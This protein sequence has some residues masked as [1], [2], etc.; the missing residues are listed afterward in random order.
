MGVE[1]EVP[2]GW[3]MEEAGV[4]QRVC[5]TQ[6]EAVLWHLREVEEEPVEEE[7]RGQTWWEVRE[8]MTKVLPRAVEVASSGWRAMSLQAE[9]MGILWK[10]E[11]AAV[12]HQE[13]VEQSV[14]LGLALTVHGVQLPSRTCM[15]SLGWLQCRR[16]H[17]CAVWASRLQKFH[18]A[19]LPAHWL[20]HLIL[21]IHLHYCF[22]VCWRLG[23][24][25]LEAQV[26]K[27]VS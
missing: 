5:E 19:E 21:Q 8:R 26:P 15:A 17:D 25:G 22:V 11:A 16:R 4:R 13:D 1:V 23:R 7:P 18:Q 24:R 27:E 6:G 14:V 9:L 10:V 3:L 20:L 2:Q 12:V